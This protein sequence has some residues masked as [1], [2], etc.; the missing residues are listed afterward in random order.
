MLTKEYSWENHDGV[1]LYVCEWQSEKKTRAVIVLVHG[2]GEHINRYLHVAE[3]LTLNQ[4][5]IIGFDQRGHGKS[6]GVRG[7]SPSFE[8][9]MNDISHFLDE[10]NSKYPGIPVFLYGH[11]LGGVEVLN[12]ILKRKPRIKG[13]IVTSPGL[14]TASSVPAAKKMLA[15][16]MDKIYPTLQVQNGLDRS[17][18]LLPRGCRKI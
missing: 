16:V 14:G 6:D 2:L 18:L 3:F 5:S 17:G 12:Y 15:K 1:K 11:S 7:H 9:S 4:F 8:A 10:A 13:A